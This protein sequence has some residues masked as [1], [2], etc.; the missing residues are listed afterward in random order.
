MQRHNAAPTPRDTEH[1]RE[2]KREG[3]LHGEASRQWSGPLLVCSI[4]SAASSLWG[5]SCVV[6][7]RVCE[8]VGTSSRFLV[9]YSCSSKWRRL[10]WR[11]RE[12]EKRKTKRPRVSSKEAQCTSKGMPTGT[13]WGVLGGS[14]KKRE[15]EEVRGASPRAAMEMRKIYV[16]TIREGWVG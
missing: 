11:C 9:L 16:R 15:R 13:R 14:E 7:V 3:R 2:I 6:P 10:G 5:V 4:T 8:C 1:E 12:Q